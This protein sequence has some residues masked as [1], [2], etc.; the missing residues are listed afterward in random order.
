MSSCGRTTAS[1]SVMAARAVADVIVA[2]AVVASTPVAVTSALVEA[3]EHVVSVARVDGVGVPLVIASAVFFRAN[4][5]F[6][7]V[8]LLGRRGCRF[9]PLLI[10]SV[11]SLEPLGAWL[12]FSVPTASFC[13]AGVV[14]VKVT[15]V[16]VLG[17]AV[18]HYRTC[19]E[20]DDL[21]RWHIWNGRHR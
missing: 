5:L 4:N 9:V 18:W 6:W 3:A 17:H 13:G 1:V 20:D 15:A 8:I 10:T 19:S 11:H 12:N 21:Q 14:G 2:G 7:W 16:F